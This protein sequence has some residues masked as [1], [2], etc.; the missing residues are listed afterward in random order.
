MLITI[1]GKPKQHLSQELTPLAPIAI[2]AFKIK[3]A[4]V[5]KLL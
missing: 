5:F 2:S 1:D 4:K 3:Y